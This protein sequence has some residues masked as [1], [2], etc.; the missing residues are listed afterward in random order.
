MQRPRIEARIEANQAESEFGTEPQILTTN[1]GLRERAE[2][3]EGSTNIQN[4]SW[5][6]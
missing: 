6:S 5:P 2:V 3:R 4:P 1:V